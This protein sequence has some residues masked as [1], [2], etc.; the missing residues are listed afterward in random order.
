M[1]ILE[2]Q[3]KIKIYDRPSDLNEQDQ[4]LLAKAKEALQ[5]AYAPY[6][7]FSVGAALLLDDQTIVPGSN[8]E[9]ASFPVGLCAE[10]AALAGKGVNYPDQK[11]L[12]I[13]VSV[14]N[15]KAQSAGSPCGMCRQALFEQEKKQGA[16]IRVLLKGPAN[17]VYEFDS[18][19]ALLPLPFSS[20][21]L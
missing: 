1:N 16:S 18:A 6:S 15:D 8:Q 20:Q 14:E 7:N 19:E 9:N 12:A 4:Q 21:N 11:I 3:T 10:R 13:A 2:I 5:T 17:E